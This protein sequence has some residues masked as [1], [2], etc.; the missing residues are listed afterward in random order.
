MSRRAIDIARRT[1]L[2]CQSGTQRVDDFPASVVSSNLLFLLAYAV[3]LSVA[4]YRAH[5]RANTGR[6]DQR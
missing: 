6:D 2:G 1:R 5:R 3:W 4:A